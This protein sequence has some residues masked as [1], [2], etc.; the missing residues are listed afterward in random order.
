MSNILP[1]EPVAA[2]SYF[3]SPGSGPA[4]PLSPSAFVQDQTSVP[5][6]ANL[7]LVIEQDSQSN[8]A[9]YKTVDNR[10]GEVVQQLPR[11]A[12]L[13][14][15]ENQNYAAGQLLKTKT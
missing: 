2:A 1:T 10:T 7:R 9:V 12:V 14:M 13:R 8:T 3:N 5:D 6:P 4:A 15:R 11:E